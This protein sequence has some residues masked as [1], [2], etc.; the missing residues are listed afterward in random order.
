[1]KS[2]NRTTKRNSATRLAFAIAVS[3]ITI[4]AVLWL[5]SGG[6]NVAASATPGIQEIYRKPAPDFDLNA[7]QGLTN[8]RSATGEQLWSERAEGPYYASPICIG[9]KGGRLCNVTRQGE[10]VVL[11]AEEKFRLIQ[12]FPLG[13]ASYA[14]PAVSGGKLF[15]RT[16]SHLISIGK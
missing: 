7:A 1:M 11:A 8:V 16:S 2:I 15:V 12:R 3:F 4:G 5:S 6:S 13:E 14:T 10:L 9:G